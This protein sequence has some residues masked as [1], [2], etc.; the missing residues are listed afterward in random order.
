MSLWLAIGL[1]WGFMAAV[2]SGLWWGQYRRHNAGIVDVAWSFGTGLCAVWFALTTGGDEAR[3]VIVALMA[4]AWGLRL[5]ST[6]AKRVFSESEDGR[7]QMLR[8]KWGARVQPLMFGFFQIQAAWSVLF[9][10][11][12]LAA[13]S[14]PSPLDWTVVVGVLVWLVAVVGESVA[15]LQLARF[16]E[17]PENKGKVCRVGLWSWSRHPNYFFEWLH[18]FAYVALAW[19]SPLFWLACAGPVVMLLFLLRVTGIPM[20]ERRLLQSKGE[21]YADYQRE[22]SAFVPL[23]PK[24]GGRS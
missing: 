20:T 9:A 4:G 7:Y 13:A 17:R 10:L 14:N 16:K 23:P 18:W 22:V 5:G 3:R 11:P 19:Q 15:D 21:P 24:S 12:M 8:Q 2:M 1:A 6:L